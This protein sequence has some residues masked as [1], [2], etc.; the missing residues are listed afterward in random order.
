MKLLI[1][2]SPGKIKKL[3]AILGKEWVISA[4]L[5]HVRDLPNKEIGVLAPDF[6]AKYVPTDKGRDVLSRLK[7]LVDEAEEVYLATDP[8]REGE[9]I[10]WHLLDALKLK[11]PKRVC[12]TA[13]T[14]EEVLEGIKNARSIDMNF[15]KAQEARR[16]LDRLCGY[17]VSPVLTKVLS[18]HYTAGRVQSPAVGLVVAR[19]K[20]INSFVPSTYYGVKALFE[21][22]DNVQDG[23]VANW[24]PDNFLWNGQ[25]YI[26][27][28]E[29]AEKIAKIKIFTVKD[30]SQND[31]KQAPP[32]PF[33][34]SSLQQSAS[35][36]LKFS[37]KKTMQ[38]A[39]KLYEHGY[40]TYMRT[41]SPN[42]SCE[43][44][45]SIRSH[46][47][48][49][50]IPFIE[51]PRIWKSKEGAQ[52]AHEAIRPTHIELEI[53]EGTKEEQEL[54]E[55]IRSRTLASQMED[56][57][58]SVRKANLEADLDDKKVH[59]EAQGRT[60]IYEGWK[61]LYKKDYDDESSDENE[62]E[63]SNPIPRLRPESLLSAVSYEVQTKKTTAPCR[64]TQASLIRELE[65]QGIGR[66]A[67]Y[68]SIIDNILQRS[69]IIEENRKLFASPKGEKMI[70]SMQGFFSFLSLEFTKNMEDRLDDIANGNHEY[71]EEVATMFKLLEN[72]I[73]EYMKK[74]A[75]P[76]PKCNSLNFKHIYSK[77]KALDFFACDDCKT[78]FNNQNGTPKER[79]PSDKK[80]KV[81]EYTCPKCQY[82]LIEKNTKNGGIW[83][84]CS[85]YPQCKERFWAD[86]DGKPKY[87]QVS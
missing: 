70:D 14:E 67:T 77:T 55:L 23:W 3:Q 37:P 84:S 49:K 82:S 53:V 59:F 47:I 12:Y 51:L 44:T 30:F 76:C 31:K 43:A 81:S 64:Y 62:E 1:V 17:M 6:I 45:S 25:D 4:S 8:D 39:Q 28:K 9:A 50:N 20:A 21:E 10:A 68:A 58:Y 27:D 79:S 71:V 83:Y 66:P 72:E 48:S 61:A 19:E 11:N 7:L 5:G 32:P 73:K 2:E 18:G 57:I 15:V 80:G 74:N 42:L 87:S 46:L 41:D 65:R 75:I 22:V 16:V 56:A 29:L 40:I 63:I 24:K 54:Y 36:T 78:T 38:V 33:T 60:L 34:T 69:Y 35:N 86:N 13:I 26:L 52:E 85:A